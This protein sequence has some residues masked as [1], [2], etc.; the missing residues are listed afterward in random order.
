MAEERV[1][2]TTEAQRKATAKRMAKM[3]SLSIWLKPEE[4]EVLRQKAAELGMSMTA[5]IKHKC[6]I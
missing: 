2:K 6:G 5:Y 4:K 3:D 1:Y